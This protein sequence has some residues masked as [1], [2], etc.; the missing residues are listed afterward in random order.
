M[1][2]IDAF[3]LGLTQGLTEFIPVSS[4]GHLQ[5]VRRLIDDDLG[6]FH[7]FLEFINLGT[8]LALIFF[9]R[10]RIKAIF[11]QIFHE[12]DYRFAINVILTSLP[13]AT[14]GLIF[15]K[16]IENTPFFSYMAV[17]ATMMA[18]VGVLM[19]NVDKLP[20]LSR[21]KDETKL[22]KKR[23]L[24]IGCAQVFALIPGTSR[25]GTTIVAGRLVGLDS[26]AA[27]EYS[28]LAS[29]PLMCGVVLKSFIS[30]DSSAF[31]M[32]NLP[33]L[34][35]S[36]IVAFLVGLAAIHLVMN[37][38]KKPHSLK[39]FGWYRVVIAAIVIIFKLIQ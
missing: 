26:R 36:N 32:E 13:V 7:L 21:L 11:R 38:L 16:F 27:A 1:T 20:K 35:F 28:F 29:I 4:S 22:T 31:I 25:S 24:A 6:N 9:Y 18:L 33:T 15:S 17:I 14:I 12:H 19:I 5:I 3:W 10:H 30:G 34:I 23:A 37:F 8:L 2:F 39:V